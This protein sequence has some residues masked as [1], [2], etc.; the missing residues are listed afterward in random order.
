MVVWGR[1]RV[2]WGIRR[3]TEKPTVIQAKMNLWGCYIQVDLE[4]VYTVFSTP[5][6]HAK[7]GH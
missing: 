5:T 7:A 3:E 4:L 2:T 1:G 6:A